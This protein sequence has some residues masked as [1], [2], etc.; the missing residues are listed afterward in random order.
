[1]LK[2]SFSVNEALDEIARHSELWNHYTQRTAGYSPHRKIDDIWVRYNDFSKYI[3]DPSFFADEHDS[4]WYPDAE[5]IPAVRSL[6]LDL[7]AEVRGERLGGVLITRVPPGESVDPH[8]DHGWHARYYEKFCIQLM[9]HPDQA[10]CFE[11]HSLSALPG[12]AYTFDNSRLHWVTNASNVPRMSL[13]VCI[14]GA[15][16]VETV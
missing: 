1:M 16:R 3:G 5:K 8:I 2:A 10:F 9:G 7:M 4:V 11:G 13:I 6:C 14:R 15:H 12:Q